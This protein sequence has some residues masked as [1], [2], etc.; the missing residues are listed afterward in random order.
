MATHEIPRRAFLKTGAASVVGIGAALTSTPVLSQDGTAPEE[1]NKRDGM[2]YRVLGRTNLLVSELTMG[3]LGATASVLAAALDKGVN[4]F[5]T[6]IAYDQGNSFAQAAQVLPDRR[7][8]VFLALKGLPSVD[9]FARWL[10]MLGVESADIVFHPLSRSSEANDENGSVRTRYQALKDRGLVRFL[11]LTVHSDVGP[12]MQTGLEAGIWDCIMPRYGLDLRTE[13]A[14]LVDAAYT[15]K[16]GVLGMKSLAGTQGD[17]MKT[18]LQTAL[19][20]P[21]LTSVLKGLPSFELLDSLVAALNERPTADEQARLWQSY[22]DRRNTMCAMC[23]K[24]SVCPNGLACEEVVMC[25][26]Y[27]DQE[28]HRPDHARQTYRALPLEQTAVR[29]ANCGTCERLCPNGLPIR[30]L[31]RTAHERYA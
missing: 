1:R 14:P 10:K 22:T 6:A 25:L 16:I 21:G 19:D 31:M 3:G 9:E 15:K 12:G 23:S 11:G 4:L 20:K 27:Y 8:E 7:E 26:L 17:Q 29:C 5:H 28:L 13:L 30:Q 2:R 18:A 24:C